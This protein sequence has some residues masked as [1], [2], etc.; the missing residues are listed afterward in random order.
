MVIRTAFWD[1]SVIFVQL[2]ARLRHSF[3]VLLVIYGALTIYLVG[4]E[5]SNVPERACR[6]H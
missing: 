2:G 1:L 5:I 3:L 6:S 4:L